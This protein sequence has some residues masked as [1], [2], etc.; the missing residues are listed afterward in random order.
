MDS[1]SPI[2]SGL[3]LLIDDDDKDDDKDDDI[4]AANAG[5]GISNGANSQFAFIVRKYQLQIFERAK[6]S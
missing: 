2:E 1:R 3:S 5:L 6:V 4:A